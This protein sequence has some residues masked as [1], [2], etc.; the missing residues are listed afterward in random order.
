MKSPFPGMDPYLEARWPN[1]HSTLISLIQETLQPRLPKMLRARSEERLLVEDSEI[2]EPLSYR[3]DV[4]IV[5]SPSRSDS[6][7]NPAGATATIEPVAITL[8]QPELFDRFVQI[9]D[10]TSGNRVVTAIE[11]LSPW[12]KLPGRLNDKYMK[13]LGDYQRAGVNIVEIDL[14]RST[15]EYLLITH[16]N[17]PQRRRATY[18]TC[19]FFAHPRKWYAYPMPLREPLGTIPI[20]LRPQDQVIGLELQPLIERAYAAGGHDDIDYTR[21]PT[22]ALAPEDASWAENL[23]TASRP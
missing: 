23:I 13:K 8:E 20:P 16:A 12:N 3:T 11:I 21:P 18:L 19:V 10:T 22:P 14:L 7:S 2:E 6:V 9:I 5:Q 1:I 17:I 4:A 15:R